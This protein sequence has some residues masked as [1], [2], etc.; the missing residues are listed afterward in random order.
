MIGNIP[1]KSVTGTKPLSTVVSYYKLNTRNNYG[2]E[3]KTR[4]CFGVASD[5]SRDAHINSLNANGSQF[6]QYFI[7]LAL[8]LRRRWF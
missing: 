2:H 4:P 7:M 8:F 1:K 3:N 5:W 6:S